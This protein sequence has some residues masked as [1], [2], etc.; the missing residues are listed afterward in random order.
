MKLKL[1]SI[2]IITLSVGIFSI[3]IFSNP[4]EAISHEAK[5]E[6]EKARELDAHKQKLMSVEI[7]S[8]N[9]K[10]D[11]LE[12]IYIGKGDNYYSWWGHVLLRFVGS[13]QTSDKDFAV[14]FLADFNDFPLDKMKGLLG[15]YTVIPKIDTMENYFHQYWVTESRDFVRFELNSTQL[16]RE[17][18]LAIVREWINDSTLPGSYS[19]I[20]NNC[21][22]LMAK[23][24]S[25]AGFEFA[26]G[27][28]YFPKSFIV[29]LQVRGVASKYSNEYHL[30]KGSK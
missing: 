20:E 16:Q 6:W 24:L 8:P 28:G 14:G 10:Y 22:G 25:Q 4:L 29:D 12:L 26:D 19:F 30:V 7:M 9:F 3:W 5:M 17:K 2:F 18:L 1:I 11:S 27:H 23:L 21:V 13:G 15:G